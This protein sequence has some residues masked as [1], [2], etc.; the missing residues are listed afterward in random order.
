[1]EIMFFIDKM[2]VLRRGVGVGGGFSDMGKQR[3]HHP[4]WC[5][6]CCLGD[7]REEVERGN[8]EAGLSSYEDE[9]EPIEPKM[10][11][12]SRSRSLSYASN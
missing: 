10:D 12:M 6:C 1:M 7:S 3:Q 4:V 9:G 5:S 2:F 11:R 8:M